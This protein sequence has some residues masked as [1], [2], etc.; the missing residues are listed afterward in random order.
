MNEVKEFLK[1]LATDP[2]AKEL[3]KGMKE[4]AST[5][6]AAEQYITIA[7]KMGF[8][9]T[10]ESILE[11]LTVMEKKQQAQAAKAQN[12]IKAA[13]NEDDLESVAGGVEGKN[14]NNSGCESTTKS[15][16]EEWC[17]FSDACN[18]VVNYYETTLPEL[19]FTDWQKCA[20]LGHIWTEVEICD[21]LTNI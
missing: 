15:A 9:V 10:K 20:D 18:Y 2:K 11:F 3:R 13:L 21:N 12:E 6:E 14:E 4:P 19:K 5:E 8:S 17:W 16:E 1:A 7:E